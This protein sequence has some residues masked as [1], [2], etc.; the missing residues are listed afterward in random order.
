MKARQRI[1]SASF[2]PEA[3]KTIQQAF[4]QAWE[5]IAS[6]YGTDPTSVEAA[7]LKLADALLSVASENSSNVEE[8]KST[9]V[10][11]LEL[12]YHRRPN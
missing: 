9:A 11:V 1:Q 7:R 8:L 6:R 3:L 4:D 12:N 10:Q 2:G 5:A